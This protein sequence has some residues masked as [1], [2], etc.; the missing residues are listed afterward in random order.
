MVWTVVKVNVDGSPAVAQRYGIGGIPTLIL[1]QDGVEK[2]RILGVV[3]QEEISETIERYKRK[4]V[5]S[6]GEQTSKRA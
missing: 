4:G 1:F 6:A 2:E 3:S 5:V